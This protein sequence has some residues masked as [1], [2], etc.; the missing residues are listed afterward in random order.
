MEAH[1][2]RR[3]RQGGG[4]AIADDLVFGKRLPQHVAVGELRA[5]IVVDL[6]VGVPDAVV[7]HDL[8]V[9]VEEE[10]ARAVEIELLA[11]FAG[12]PDAHDGDRAVRVEVHLHPRRV[13][14]PH[15]RLAADGEG[16]I[17]FHVVV[18]LSRPAH[19][20]DAPGEGLRGTGVVHH[21]VP[22]AG[23]EIAEVLFGEGRS[24]HAGDHDRREDSYT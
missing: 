23:V 5:R 18:V 24:G 7:P 13:D 9:L 10:D 15:V 6:A 19:V 20:E 14:A 11:G 12:R 22:G 1:V 17:P 3:R 21:H 4:H 16:R 2:R 8:P